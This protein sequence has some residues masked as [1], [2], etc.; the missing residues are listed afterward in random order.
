MASR[1]RGRRSSRRGIRA[2]VYWQQSRF[3]HTLTSAG[4]TSVTDISHALIQ[5][6]AEPGGTVMRMI[7]D[8]QMYAEDTSGEIAWAMG[9]SLSTLDGIQGP[10]DPIGD[11]Q[12]D[13]YYWTGS[14]VSAISS[15]LVAGESANPKIAVDIRSKRRLREGFRLIL[16]SESEPTGSTQPAILAYNIRTLWAL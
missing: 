11:A 6:S 14:P 9:V 12:Q 1:Q 7:L 15:G 3:V 16:V 10:P 4:S 13:W 8:M 5:S 2:R